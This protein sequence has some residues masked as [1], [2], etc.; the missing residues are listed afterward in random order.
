MRNP[1]TRRL[2]LAKRQLRI[3]DAR[4]AALSKTRPMMYKDLKISPQQVTNWGKRGISAPML[5]KMAAYIGADPEALERGEYRLRAVITVP[6]AATMTQE[7]EDLIT[8][9]RALDKAEQ[10]AVWKIMRAKWRILAPGYEDVMPDLTPE[11]AAQ[12]NRILQRTKDD[13]SP[14]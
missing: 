5:L 1:T 2:E 8:A 7:D 10:T 4:L 13:T 9:Y 3:V 12:I 11:K 6:E 14:R